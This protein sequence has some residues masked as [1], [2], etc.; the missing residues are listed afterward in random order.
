MRAL[1]IMLCATAAALWGAYPSPIEIAVSANGSRLYVVC[2]GT[3]EV[4]EVDA[5][6]GTVVRRVGVGQHPKSVAFRRTGGNCTWRIRGA[7]RY[8]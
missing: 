6:A 5:A 4:V 7:T 8:P 2:E 1:L 3:D